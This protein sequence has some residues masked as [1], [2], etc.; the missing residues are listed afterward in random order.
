MTKMIEELFKDSIMWKIIQ[1]K[2]PEGINLIKLYNN[3][4]LEGKINYTALTSKKFD[5][6]TLTVSVS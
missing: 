1:D 6:I 3:G 2:L 4:M 5:T